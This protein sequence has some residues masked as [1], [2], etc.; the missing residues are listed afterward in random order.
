MT[1]DPTI[2]ADVTDLETKLDTFTTSNAALPALKSAVDTATA[3]YNAA[4][5]QAASDKAA[6]DASFA[7]LQADIQTIESGGTL[8]P[9][10]PTVP[11]GGGNDVPPSN[12]SVSNGTQFN[13]GKS[14]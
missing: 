9:S 6:V 7:T 1:I 12:G 3:G 5:A 13:F 14:K 2:L 4:V 10:T 8:P 11:G